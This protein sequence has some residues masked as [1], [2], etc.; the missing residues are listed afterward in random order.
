VVRGCRRRRPRQPCRRSS[1][2]LSATPGGFPTTSRRRLGSVSEASRPQPATSSLFDCRPG[3]GLSPQICRL[4][5]VHTLGTAKLS[6]SLS[7]GSAAAE[8]QGRSTACGFVEKRSPQTVD[9]AAVH[10]AR[11]ELSTDSP[12]AEAC[13]PQRT[14]VFPHLCPLFGNEQT[15][16]TV[17]SERRH[18]ELPDW[19]VQNRGKTGDA[20]GDNY[21]SPVH[22]VC[23]TF[24]SPQMTPVFHRLRPQD[25]WTK[26]SL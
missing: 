26:N 17:S 18:T 23:R 20:A 12:Q 21:P 9:E 3:Y 22:G 13:C 24:V 8:H 14:A 7:T 16:L 2:A 1:A 5:C 11:F 6:Q 4:F 25:Q 10:R 19:P 15:R